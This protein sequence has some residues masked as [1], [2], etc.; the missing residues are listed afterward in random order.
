M[1]EE[2]QAQS[3]GYLL[4]RWLGPGGQPEERQAVVRGRRHVYRGPGD[5]GASC[6]RQVDAVQS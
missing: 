1:S 6:F 3:A 2:M 4:S 5:K